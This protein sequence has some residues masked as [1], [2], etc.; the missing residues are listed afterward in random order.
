MKQFFKEQDGLGATPH[1][2]YKKR[3][4]FGTVLGGCLSCFASAF[5]I[6]YVAL[7]SSAFVFGGRDFNQ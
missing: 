2:T 1:M 5:V 4:T 6:T 7:I 3:E